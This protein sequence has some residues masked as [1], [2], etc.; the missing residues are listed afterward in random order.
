M[1]RIIKYRPREKSKQTTPTATSFNSVPQDDETTE[2]EPEP[3]VDCVVCTTHKADDL[4]AARGITPRIL[5]QKNVLETS[6]NDCHT[7]RRPLDK[8]HFKVEYSHINQT[9]RISETQGRPSQHV[10]TTRTPMY[11][12][13]KVHGDNNDL[14][15][16]LTWLTTAQDSLKWGLHGERFWR[17]ADSEE[18]RKTHD[19]ERHVNSNRTNNNSTSNTDERNP[20]RR[21]RRHTAHPHPKN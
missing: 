12:P 2:D 6:Q 15:N 9:E 7:P 17:V 20:R 8:A 13:K 16:D 18:S 1:L 21:R 11:N 4:L 3:W 14:T 10:G 19:H 5:R